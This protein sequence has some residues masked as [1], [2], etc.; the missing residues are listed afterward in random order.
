[1]IVPF[2]EATGL[3][4]PIMIK[5]NMKAQNMHG[6]AEKIFD[7]SKLNR[8]L[9]NGHGHNNLQDTPAYDVS[10]DF[11]NHI[12]AEKSK[13]DALEVI[14]NGRDIKIM[15]KSFKEDADL[16]NATDNSFHLNG[17]SVTDDIDESTAVEVSLQESG[18][19]EITDVSNWDDSQQ[20][21]GDTKFLFCCSTNSDF[22]EGSSINHF[23]GLQIGLKTVWN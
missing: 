3:T 16:N 1:M 11:A 6:K 14:V 20:L 7:K 18:S 4:I 5:Q 17:T 13:H 19:G 21:Q 12:N 22:N 15:S 23:C 9:P 2:C 10:S 8:M